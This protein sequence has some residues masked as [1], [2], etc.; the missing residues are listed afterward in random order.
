MSTPEIG[1]SWR[2]ANQTDAPFLYDLITMVDP[3]WWRFSRSGLD[4]RGV[5]Q[6]IDTVS[7][8][9]VVLDSLD[10]PV[11]CAVLADSGASGTAT[12]EYFALPTEEARAVAAHFAGQII[13]AA[14]A[15]TSVR[16][17]YHERFESDPELLGDT[18][19]LWELEVTYPEFALIEG[20]H[21]ARTISVLTRAR[22]DRWMAD[23]FAEPALA[24]PALAEPEGA[25]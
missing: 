13:A 5:L 19:P 15:G 7:A 16:R 2:L 24:E 20:R 9:V 3:R 14:F 6:L 25:R 21:Q 11:A 12:F 8:A 22:F 23:V 17:L 10:R 18:T 1:G 4:P